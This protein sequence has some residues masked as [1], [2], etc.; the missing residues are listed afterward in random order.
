[1]SKRLTSK[2]LACTVALLGCLAA[3]AA[4]AQS[5]ACN[6]AD[7]S[8]SVWNFINETVGL[9]F[10]NKVV[11]I[12]TAFSKIARFETDSRLTAA[13]QTDASKEQILA[14]S[15]DQATNIYNAAVNAAVVRKF[16]AIKANTSIQESDYLISDNI[17]AL[18][19]LQGDA[20]GIG[21]SGKGAYS[22]ATMAK[23][24][25][26]QHRHQLA[27]SFDD[28]TESKGIYG[29]WFSTATDI[30]TNAD[31]AIRDM[32]KLEADYG[33]A[34]DRETSTFIRLSWGSYSLSGGIFGRTKNGPDKILYSV[35]MT[36]IHPS[37]ESGPRADGVIPSGSADYCGTKYRE[38]LA[39][40]QGKQNEELNKYKQALKA[41]FLTHEKFGELRNHVRNLRSETQTRLNKRSLLYKAPFK[42]NITDVAIKRAVND[43]NIDSELSATN[44]TGLTIKVNDDPIVS[45]RCTDGTVRKQARGGVVLVAFAARVSAPKTYRIQLQ[46]EDGSVISSRDIAVDPG[47]KYYYANFIPQPY[48]LN[49]GLAPFAHFVKIDSVA[50]GAL[51]LAEIYA[52]GPDASAG[53]ITSSSSTGGIGFSSEAV[54]GSRTTGFMSDP[55]FL[56]SS[57][58]EWWEGVLAKPTKINFIKLLV[59]SPFKENAR[60]DIQLFGQNGL[61]FDKFSVTQPSGAGQVGLTEG[62][63]GQIPAQYVTKV[64]ISGPPGQLLQVWE[65]EVDP[66]AYVGP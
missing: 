19:A 35:S 49:V 65:V 24:V 48:H 55:S 33:T 36:C 63:C 57:R 10:D 44:W 8:I 18:G 51:D 23:L 50:G 60:F 2:K 21:V 4:N 66:I 26:L 54:D 56:G 61:V 45:S 22:M 14:A 34:V 31:N 52:F 28:N 32:N 7:A 62:L 58:V 30:I 29:R 53:M 12:Y 1:M 17:Q 27:H 47:T 43:G 39:M 46:K 3:P 5:T 64:K 20:L 13:C 59:G 11:K 42:D 6:V 40:L 9:V 15:A 16:N 41:E 37:G 38:Q 25:L